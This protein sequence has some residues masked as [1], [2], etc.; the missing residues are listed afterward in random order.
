[1]LRLA[2]RLAWL[3]IARGWD[4]LRREGLSSFWVKLLA[5]TVFRQLILVERPLDEPVPEVKAAADVEVAILDASEIAEYRRFRP[6]TPEAEIRARLDAGQRCF[7]ARHAGRIVSARWAAVDR[8]WIDY[9]SCE[10]ALAPGEGYPYD[11][12]TAPEFRGHAFSPATSAAMLRHF[13]GAGFRRMVGTVLPGNE[14]SFR[15]SAKT[16]YRPC[17]RI[18]CVG[19]GPW[20]W[21]FRVDSGGA[22]G[23]GRGRGR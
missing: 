14:A 2:P 22:A 18:G 13:Q 23:A 17:G 5:A 6:D 4:V 8:V 20:I 7:A 21:R 19:M 1:V 16:G 12:Y 15:A 10:L 3:P 9:L 11:L